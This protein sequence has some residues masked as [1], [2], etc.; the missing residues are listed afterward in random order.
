MNA[1]ADRGVSLT[2]MLSP[3]DSSPLPLKGPRL[4]HGGAS[5]QLPMPPQEPRWSC[6]TACQMS[7]TPTHEALIPSGSIGFVDSLMTRAEKGARAGKE[8][9]R[10]FR[11]GSDVMSGSKGVNHLPCL[12]LGSGMADCC[13]RH[14]TRR[15]SEDPAFGDEPVDMQEYIERGNQ[16]VKAGRFK[17]A[18]GLFSEALKACSQQRAVDLDVEVDIIKSRA[19]CWK[20]IGCFAELQEEGAAARDFCWEAGKWL[21]DAQKVLKL[22][23][24]R[25]QDALDWLRVAEDGLSRRRTNGALND[26][27]NRTTNAVAPERL[28]QAPPMTGSHGVGGFG[29]KCSQCNGLASKCAQCGAGMERCGYCSQPVSRANCCSRCHCTYYCGRECQRSH[30]KVHK[31]PEQIGGTPR[32]APARGRDAGRCAGDEADGGCPLAGRGRCRGASR[33]GAPGATGHQ[34]RCDSW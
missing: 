34:Q 11:N 6:P 5:W 26:A 7:W 19:K 4:L 12:A 10:S 14:R 17:A 1:Q 23:G 30:W 31:L 13:K 25:D 16:M 2:E 32:A 9:R 27:T 24:N 21:E 28:A 3:R 8:R 22:T 29:A 20:A 15:P 18:S 33:S